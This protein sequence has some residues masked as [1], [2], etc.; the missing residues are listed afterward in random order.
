MA[1]KESR[2]LRNARGGAGETVDV[3]SQCQHLARG[4][5]LSMS[6]HRPGSP[7]LC[8]ATPTWP[9]RCGLT[10]LN[11]STASNATLSRLET[12][13][14]WRHRQPHTRL[15]VDVA[16]SPSRMTVPSHPHSSCDHGNTRTSPFG[17]PADQTQRAFQAINLEPEENAE[18]QIDTTK[19][20]HVRRMVAI[21]Y[22][23]EN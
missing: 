6:R 13:G 5:R 16:T 19:E 22:K 18:E 20:I 10:R 14:S 12:L 7:A 21:V 4:T 3:G 11:I 17:P 15:Q 9:R 23:P 1:K 8:C 2:V